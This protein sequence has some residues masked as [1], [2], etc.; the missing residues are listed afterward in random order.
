MSQVL[1]FVPGPAHGLPLVAADVGPMPIVAVAE[2]GV[3]HR[4]LETLMYRFIAPLVLVLT[5]V[6]CGAAPAPTAQSAV[7]AFKAAGLTLTNVAA[8][9]YPAD[10]PAPHSYSSQLGFELPGL[11]PA[12]RGGQVMACDTKKNCDA[13][14]AYFTAMLALAGPYVYQSPD[15]RVVVQLNS[16]MKP[17]D[18]AKVAAVVA[19]LP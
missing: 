19:T 15:G 5:L 16:G 3:E 6:G 11:A 4:T 14:V 2:S 13:M 8:T 12:G 9:D 7:D 1:F 17:E 10:S 18:A